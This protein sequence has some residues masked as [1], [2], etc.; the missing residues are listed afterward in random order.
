MAWWYCYKP[1]C[2]SDE[3]HL[4]AE[5][6][7]HTKNLKHLHGLTTCSCYQYLAIILSGPFVQS[8][9][10]RHARTVDE[11]QSLQIDNDTT[12]TVGNIGDDIVGRRFELADVRDI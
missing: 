4:H 7:V 5:D 9:D 11:I 2:E 8:D 10:C 12:P 3:L 6:L 1:P